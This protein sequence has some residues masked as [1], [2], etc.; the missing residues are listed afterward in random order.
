[1]SLTDQNPITFIAR[2]RSSYKQ[3]LA[4]K[5]NVG[6]NLP[7]G[8]LQNGLREEV[9]CQDSQIKREDHLLVCQP[10]TFY[11]HLPNERTK[12]KQTKNW[13][14]IPFKLYYFFSEVFEGF[15]ID[16]NPARKKSFSSTSVQV[17]SWQIK[18]TEL[19]TAFLLQ[20]GRTDYFLCQDLFDK[21]KGETIRTVVMPF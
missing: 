3:L 13:S 2:I 9:H 16:I 18:K 15:L 6:I 12:Y 1:M 20:V 11:E 7:S 5:H 14:L 10:S 19:S 4:E 21:R 8:S 17:Q